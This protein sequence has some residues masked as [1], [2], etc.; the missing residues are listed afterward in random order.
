MKHLNTILS[1]LFA[2]PY[3]LFGPSYFLHYMPEPPME[4]DPA[5][6]AGLLA[7]SGYMAFIK[8]LEIGLGIMIMFNFH[9]PLA[10]L[11]IAPI[12]LNILL[13]EIFIMHMPAIGLVMTILNAVLIYR[14]RKN[15]FAIVDRSANTP[16]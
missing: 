6:F 2:I 16:A 14:Y 5:V 3:V 12:T 10:L 8:V 15:Y 4:G 9:R 7:N 1:V 13:F 11:L